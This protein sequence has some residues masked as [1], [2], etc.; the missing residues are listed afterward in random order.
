MRV[1]YMGT[2]DFAVPTLKHLA[3]NTSHNVV[4]VVTAQD[5]PKGR[6]RELKSPVLKLCALDLNIPT[7]QPNNLRDR[8]F[9]D[10]LLKLNPDVLVVVAFRI[11]PV[12]LFS[13]TR[14]GAI[15]LHASLLPSYRGPAPVQWAIMNG[16][17]TTGLTTFQIDNGIDTGNILLQR[18]LEIEDSETAGELLKR[19]ADLG[20]QVVAESLDGLEKGK[21]EALTQVSSQSSHAPKITPDILPIDWNNPA[22]SIVNK[23]RGLSPTP[24]AQTYYKGKLIKLF[25]AQSVEL[26]SSDLKPGTILKANSKDGLFVQAGCNVVEI[27]ELQR[28]GKKQ[29]TAKEMLRGMNIEEGEVLKSKKV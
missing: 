17:Q 9:L 24:S 13:L 19:L 22:Q 28:E 14:F 20:A 5:K 16:E 12:E 23:V 8:E 7:L 29:M 6:G 11:L 18:S 21:L 2:P 3:Q 10:T 15:N 27:L 26:V 1:V 4:T 25:R